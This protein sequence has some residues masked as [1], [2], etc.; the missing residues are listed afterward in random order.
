[1]ETRETMIKC[2]S[3]TNP[4]QFCLCCHYNNILLKHLQVKF[5]QQSRTI[6]QYT[7]K[8]LLQEWIHPSNVSWDRIKN[9]I[10]QF[11]GIIKE[12]LTPEELGLVDKIC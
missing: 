9:S 8:L 5:R 7:G 4:L 12:S 6:L 11:K 2:L 3:Y 10:E 1:M